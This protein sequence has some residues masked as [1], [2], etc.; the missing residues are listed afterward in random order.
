MSERARRGRAGL[1]VA[2]LLA[3][4]LVG[5]G[6]SPHSQTEQ[7]LQS[8]ASWASAA[9]LTTEQWLRGSLPDRYAA[10]ALETAA[11][12]LGQSSGFVALGALPATRAADA[13]SLVHRASDGVTRIRGAIRNGHRDEVSSALAPLSDIAKRLQALHDSVEHSNNQ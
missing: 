13:D 4:L 9:T 5:C 11:G 6:K 8:A 1:S 12:A 7:Q 3:P 2:A 10:S